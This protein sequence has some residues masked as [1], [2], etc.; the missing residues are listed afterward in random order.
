MVVAVLVGLG[1]SGRSSGQSFLAEERIMKTHGRRA[2]ALADRSIRGRRGVAGFTL[3]ELLVVIAIIGMLMALLLPAVQQAKETA[4]RAV[5]LNN[6]T[7]LV[8][9]MMNYDTTKSELPG[10]VN[11]IAKG[12]AGAGDV[13]GRMATWVIMLFPYMERNDIWSQWN[14][15]SIPSSSLPA[16]YMELLVCPSNPPT[17]L[18]QPWLGY[19]VNCGR[20][21]SPNRNVGTVPPQSPT[22]SG[23]QQ[24]EKFGN[25]IFFNRFNDPKLAGD[26][27]NGMTPPTFMQFSMSIGKIPD[28]ASNTLMLSENTAAFQ[29]T[30]RDS[31][32]PTRMVTNDAVHQYARPVDAECATGMVWDKT[33]MTSTAPPSSPAQKI[34]GTDRNFETKR[35]AGQ[36]GVSAPPFPTIGSAQGSYYARPSS[37]HPG[38]VNAAFCGGEVL[39]LREDLDYKVYKQLMTSDGKHSD[40]ADNQL[41]QDSDYK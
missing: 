4:R 41:L 30:Y 31:P 28:G 6:E 23:G 40:D 20:Q 21:D 14:D 27:Y 18:D 24:A 22:T 37:L 36:L 39:F 1:R 11:A 5:C 33:A 8:K 16:P 34:N 29:Y 12:A 26:L 19:V 17:T 9:A 7:Q 2:L 35:F 32:N 15:A 10:Y 3:V 13:H 25:G 38:G